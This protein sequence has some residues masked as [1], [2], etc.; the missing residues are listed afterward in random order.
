MNERF[1]NYLRLVRTPNNLSIVSRTN[2]GKQ[3]LFIEI[4]LIENY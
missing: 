1:Y 2:I 3:D 4:N